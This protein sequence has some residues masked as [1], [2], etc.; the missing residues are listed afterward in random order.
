[1]MGQVRLMSAHRLS[2]PDD[3]DLYPTPPWGGR[4]GAELVKQLDPLAWSAWE[5]ACGP[6]HLTYALRDYFGQVEASD[7]F[8]YGWNPIY[9]FTT[10]GPSP[11]DVDWIVTNPPFNRS[12]DFIRLALA[13][14]RRGV[15]LLMRTQ[16]LDSLGRHPLMY[17]AQ[18]LT[19]L[20]PF[21]ERLPMHKGRWEPDGSTAA[22]YSWFIWLKPCAWGV[23]G[24]PPVVMGKA[25]PWV[26][27]I[28]PGTKVRLSRP[29]DAARWGAA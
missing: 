17:G 8:D 18:P 14:A 6:G 24:P 26:M 27:D 22:F 2:P 20:A 3:A 16:A 15:A 4:A 11:F 9:D 13:R 7:A 1:M 29:D 12:A 19:V 28:P 25:R 10:P 23:V 5:C 21:C